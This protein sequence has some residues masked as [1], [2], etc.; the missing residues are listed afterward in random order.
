M[1]Y[2][3]R[4]HD[5]HP[6]SA[7]LREEVVAGLGKTHKELPCKFFYDE[8]GSELFGRICELDEYYPTRTEVQI[9]HTYGKEMAESVGPRCLLIEYGSGSSEK[10]R[11]LLDHLKDPVAYVPI[12][13]SKE[14]LLDSSRHISAT[15]RPRRDPPKHGWCISPDP[16]S[17]TSTPRTHDGFSFEWQNRPVPTVTC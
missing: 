13:I 11:I 9:M 14:H 2:S 12:D 4:L 16:P 17:A 6:E 1:S 8:R 10:T 3:I 15:Y 7:D 5:Y